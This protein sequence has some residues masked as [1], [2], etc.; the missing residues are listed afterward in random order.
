MHMHHYFTNGDFSTFS[1]RQK[2][3][4]FKSSKYMQ[5]IFIIMWIGQIFRERLQLFMHKDKV[6]ILFQLVSFRFW[7]FD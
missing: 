2:T 4:Y 1:L 3:P 7:L 6:N 5:I